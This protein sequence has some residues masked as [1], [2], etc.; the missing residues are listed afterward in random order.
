MVPDE[1]GIA[2]VIGDGGEIVMGAESDNGI[3]SYGAAAPAGQDGRERIREKNVGQR[4]K[5]KVSKPGIKRC[6][7]SKRCRTVT[8]VRRGV[9]TA[10]QK[11]WTRKG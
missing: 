5:R 6:D 4:E 2:G 7:D 8:K 3:G 10:P 1:G 9:A 11:K